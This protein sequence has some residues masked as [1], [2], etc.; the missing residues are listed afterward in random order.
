MKGNSHNFLKIQ[1]LSIISLLF[2]RRSRRTLKP[3]TLELYFIAFGM[4]RWIDPFYLCSIHILV[5]Q[6]GGNIV[7]PYSSVLS[8]FNLLEV[9]MEKFFP[10][11]YF[12]KSLSCKILSS[13]VSI[14]LHIITL[15]ICR[16]KRTPF[17]TWFLASLTDSINKTYLLQ[18]DLKTRLSMVKMARG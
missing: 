9:L 4:N 6:R 15:D 16:L 10:F 8:S 11:T 12:C 3:F 18:K 5:Q 2:K 1:F 13:M 17:S 14:Q 7:T